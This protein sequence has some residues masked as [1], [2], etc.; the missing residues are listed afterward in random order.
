MFSR[1]AALLILQ[2]K[3]MSQMS[4][5]TWAAPSAA[6]DLLNTSAAAI[7]RLALHLRAASVRGVLTVARGSSDHAAS[8]FAYL[9]LTR[10][11]VLVTSLPPSAI[12]LHNAPIDAAQLAA[13]SFSQSG[14]SPDLVAAMAGLR[15]RG[16]TTAAFVNDVAS[17]LARGVEHCI[18]LAAG[19]EKSIAATKSFVAQLLAGVRLV[20]AWS[21]DTVLLR[22]LE[23]LPDVLEQALSRDWSPAITPLIHADRLLV[24]ARGAS[25]AI[26]AEM[27]LKFKEVCGIQAEAFSAA[28]VKHGPMALIG[29][30]YPLLVLAPR[31]PEQAEVLA[32]AEQMRAQGAVV[33]LAAPA[34]E[35]SAQLPIAVAAHD[36]LDGV[37]MIQ[38][39][40]VMVEALARARGLNPDQ[41]PRLKKVTL[42]Q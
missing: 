33:L 9:L 14:Q 36:A 39:F 26:A 24:I 3:L 38:S 41:P 30:G 42:T 40:Y 11:G 32:F 27:A 18:D 16:A 31:G 34:N 13:I 23:S 21:N 37:S 22:A 2:T 10:L 7:D 20:A 19:P 1:K 6:R 15:R 35:P 12:T 29:A 4:V 8:H 17:P 5:E 25:L 28:E